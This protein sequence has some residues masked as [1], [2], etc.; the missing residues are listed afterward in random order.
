MT[1][2][3]WPVLPHGPIEQLEEN[4]WLVTGDLPRIGLKRTMTLARMADGRLAIYN[5]VALDPAAMQALERLGDPAV[6]LVP[7]AYHRIDAARFK[8]RYPQSKV[9]CPTAARKAVSK[10]VALDGTYDDFPSDP[11]VSVRLLGGLGGTEGVMFVR[12]QRGTTAVVNDCLFNM[13]H[14]RGLG[15]FITR[16]IT[17]S[18]AGPRVSRLARLGLVKDKAAYRAEL[19]S[20]ASMPGLIR[21]VVAHHVPITESVGDTLRAVAKTL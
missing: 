11:S 5:A 17:Q 14:N 18:S 21:V 6:L 16:Y 7:S 2:T 3:A 8:T 13:P 9:L 4:L 19:E 12:S 1:N 10:V 15:G 20:L